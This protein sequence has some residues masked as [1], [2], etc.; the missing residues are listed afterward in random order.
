MSALALM[1]AVMVRVTMGR[2]VVRKGVAIIVTVGVAAKAEAASTATTAP[3]PSTTAAAAAAA[4]IKV[5]AIVL[6]HHEIAGS[7]G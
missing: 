4:A 6:A 5:F 3:A 7:V 1:Q 2:I